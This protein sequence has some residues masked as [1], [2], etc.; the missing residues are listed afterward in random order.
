MIIGTNFI[1]G[2][3][4]KSVA[5][6]TLIREVQSD[7]GKVADLLEVFLRAGVNAILGHIPASLTLMDGIKEAE[8]RS[9]R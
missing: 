1:L 5:K 4:H 9:G 2:F 3:S 7:S 8:D 6:D